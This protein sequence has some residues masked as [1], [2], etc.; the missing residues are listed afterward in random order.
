MWK[1]ESEHLTD[2]NAIKVSTIGFTKKKAAD[3]FRI[4]QDSGIKRLYDIRLNNASQLAGFT[5]RD[6]LQYFLNIIADIE[7]SHKP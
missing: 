4:L 3:F 5:K 6:D 7:Y 2:H 1:K